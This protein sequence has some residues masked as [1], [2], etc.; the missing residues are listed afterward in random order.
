MCFVVTGLVFAQQPAPPPQPTI[1]TQVPLV[2]AP[3]TV[4]D[5]RGKLIDGLTAEDFVVTDEGV[6][7]NITLD[8]RTPCS[9][10]WRWSSRWKPVGS[11]DRC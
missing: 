2:L 7:Q 3:A 11:R 5:R 10:Q 9:R 1:S 4:T 6:R 8:T